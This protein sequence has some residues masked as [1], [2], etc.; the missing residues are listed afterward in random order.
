MTALRSLPAAE[1]PVADG[2][3]A[4]VLR[5]LKEDAEYIDSY[6]GFI[7]SPQRI[8]DTQN[9]AADLLR[10]LSA[11]LEAARAAL[12][13]PAVWTEAERDGMVI[14][15]DREY[16]RHGISETLFAVAAFILRHRARAFLAKDNP[17]DV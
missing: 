6:V 10:R 5:D 13:P 2:E 7:G 17:N 3:V 8:I 9:A 1:R 11:D 12:T 14:T 15:F 4:A 16:K